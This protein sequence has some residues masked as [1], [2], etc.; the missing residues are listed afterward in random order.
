MRTTPTSRPTNPNSPLQPHT[1]AG[2]SWPTRRESAS[3]YAGEGL[4]ELHFHEID[5]AGIVLTAL[6]GTFFSHDHGRMPDAATVLDDPSEL[7]LRFVD[8]HYKHPEVLVE[9]VRL[10]RQATDRGAKK[11]GIGMLWEVLRWRIV[12]DELPFDGDGFKLNNDLRSR[13]ARLMMILY[14]DLEGVFEIRELRSA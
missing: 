10:A 12:L 13:Y 6:R 9:L 7:G 8:F 4:R 14:P 11:I 5:A 2:G 3:A 1:H